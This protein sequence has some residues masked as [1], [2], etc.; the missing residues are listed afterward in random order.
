M[1]IDGVMRVLRDKGWSVETTRTPFG[2]T[3]EI[4]RKVGHWSTY[5][6]VHNDVDSPGVW[7]VGQT[8]ALCETPVWTRATPPTLREAAREA[9]SALRSMDE[10]LL[11][12]THLLED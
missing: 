2:T 8:D 1:D 10:A 3:H 5:V 9:R 12:L 4:R 6:S 7:E 11:L